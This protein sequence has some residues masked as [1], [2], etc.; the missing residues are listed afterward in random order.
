MTPKYSPIL[1]WPPKNIHKIFIPPNIL[2]FL[3]TPKNIENQNFEPQKMARAYVC[4]KISEF[5][6]GWR[7]VISSCTRKILQLPGCLPLPSH[8]KRNGYSPEK[9]NEKVLQCSPFIILYMGSIG[10]EHVISKMCYKGTILQKN[11]RKNYHYMVI[12]LIIPLQTSML[13][14]GVL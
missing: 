7:L 1:W 13:Y 2:I 9:T 5:P 10:T 3:K 11:Y 4:M 6:L 12:F 14:Q 8:F